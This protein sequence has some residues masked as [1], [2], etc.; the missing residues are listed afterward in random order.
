MDDSHSYLT[1]VNSC[2]QMVYS[3][4]KLRYS[5]SV[6]VRMHTPFSD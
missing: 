6:Q 1:L 5:N 2:M 4:P 3:S